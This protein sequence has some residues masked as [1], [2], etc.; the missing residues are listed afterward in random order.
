MT[1]FVW[2]GLKKNNEIMRGEC[3]SLLRDGL[4]EGRERLGRR[5]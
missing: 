1:L 2:S 5:F 3:V 4:L